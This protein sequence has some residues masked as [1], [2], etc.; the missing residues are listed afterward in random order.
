MGSTVFNGW[1]LGKAVGGGGAF[2]ALDP[3][4][5]VLPQEPRTQREKIS[6]SSKKQSPKALK[7]SLASERDVGL[8]VNEL[9]SGR[10]ER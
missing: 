4:V 8:G 10:R 6:W 2:H 9:R 5:R 7:T 3:I 1:T